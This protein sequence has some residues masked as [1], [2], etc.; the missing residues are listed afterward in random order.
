ML[1]NSQKYL[2]WNIWVGKCMTTTTTLAKWISHLL[3]LILNVCG[4][5]LFYSLAW[6]AAKHFGYLSKPVSIGQILS[7]LKNKK[8]LS[9]FQNEY[10]WKPTFLLI[11]KGLR[12]S[13]T[14]RINEKNQSTAIYF[15]IDIII[16]SSVF[17]SNK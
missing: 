8:K 10:G 17:K 16:N 14:C 9:V 6:A 7:N 5:P 12:N 13:I 3:Q 15:Y 2:Y 4:P 1:N 11:F